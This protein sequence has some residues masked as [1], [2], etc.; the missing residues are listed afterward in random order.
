MNSRSVSGSYSLYK[1]GRHKHIFLF[2]E[3]LAGLEPATC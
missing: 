3:L 2:M 1:K